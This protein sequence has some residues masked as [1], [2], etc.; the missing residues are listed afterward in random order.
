V[1]LPINHVDVNLHP[2]KA[3]VAILHEDAVIHGIC[4]S[5]Q[6]VLKRHHGCAPRQW[7]PREPLQSV[8]H[9]CLDLKV[10]L[11]PCRMRG[12]GTHRGAGTSGGQLEATR[13]RTDQASQTIASLARAPIKH[14][15]ETAACSLP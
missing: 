11:A 12:V 10:A 15:G 6:D 1:Q 7:Q 5:A 4:T 8:L 3:E 14:A 9:P 13:V 2:T